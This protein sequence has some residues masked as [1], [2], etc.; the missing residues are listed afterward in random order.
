MESK[1]NKT[2][3][4]HIR[5]EPEVKEKSEII[6]KKLGLNTSYAVSMFLNQIIMRDGL[7]F[8]VEVP[9]E[10]NLSK[11]LTEQNNKIISLYLSGA[12]DFE[13]AMFA[14][15]RNLKNIKVQND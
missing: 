10:T 11:E 1:V 4:I 6:L 13:S 12:I 9:K 15:E 8:D 14:I 3:L 2:E 5:I 7:P